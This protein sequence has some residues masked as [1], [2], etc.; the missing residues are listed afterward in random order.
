MSFD[1]RA[2][3]A[4]KHQ[5]TQHEELEWTRALE[6][7][8][9]S[10]KQMDIDDS[11]L[12]LLAL[13][14]SMPAKFTVICRLIYQHGKSH[15]QSDRISD[16]LF[17]LIDTSDFTLS[18]WLNAIEC[19]C[20]WLKERDQKI[21]FFSLLKYLECCVASSEAQASGQTLFELAQNMLRVYGYE[22]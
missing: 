12:E 16:F 3:A 15:L 11:S 19:L 7:A 17:E 21:D 18:D 10:L 4:Q 8:R 2:L 1:V 22:D 14:S 5:E 9:Q 13:A 20:R 6:S